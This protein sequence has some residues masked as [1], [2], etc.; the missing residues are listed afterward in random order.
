MANRR[1]PRNKK[2]V[3]TPKRAE[4]R[5]DRQEEL[6]PAEMSTVALI[7]ARRLFVDTIVFTRD[8]EVRIALSSKPAQPIDFIET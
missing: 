8:G 2:R 7:L 3:G 6:G 4:Q 5:R 1:K